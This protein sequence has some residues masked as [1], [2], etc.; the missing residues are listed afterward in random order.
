MKKLDW[1]P[2]LLIVVLLPLVSYV[3][4]YFVVSDYEDSRFN[5]SAR[6]FPSERMA[7]IFE[8]AIKDAQELQLQPI[9]YA[10]KEAYFAAVRAEW[11]RINGIKKARLEKAS[12]AEQQRAAS[13]FKDIIEE[14]SD[15]TNNESESD[16]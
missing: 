4:A 5:H 13:R 16:S 7:T 1:F 15:P 2:I 12:E 14:Q 3:G 8:Q 11:K 10:Q 9:S 6:I